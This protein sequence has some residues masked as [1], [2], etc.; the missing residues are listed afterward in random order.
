M[1]IKEGVKLSGLRPEMTV[2]L[3]AVGRIWSNLGASNNAV[4]T[5]A[6]DGKHSRASLHYVGFAIDVRLP[7]YY[8]GYNEED[9]DRAVKA[10]KSSL[11]DQFDVILEETHIHIEFQPKE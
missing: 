8:Y 7:N 1:K 4:I 2:A 3:L 10:L 5:S 11:G 6:L 9:N